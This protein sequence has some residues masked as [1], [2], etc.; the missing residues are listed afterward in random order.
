MTTYLLAGGG[1]DLT[2]PEPWLLLERGDHRAAVVE[3]QAA[4]ACLRETAPGLVAGPVVVLDPDGCR[5]GTLVAAV[6][7]G[8]VPL[9]VAISPD[10]ALLVTD[11]RARVV[12]RGQ[13]WVVRPSA[14][15]ARV[16]V[17]GSGGLVDL[18][19]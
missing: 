1:P 12:G 3:G 10:A 2:G 11:G 15:G 4:L 6:V 16:A 14:A 8:S 13:V 7:G 5:L 19:G 18:E 17:V 9:A